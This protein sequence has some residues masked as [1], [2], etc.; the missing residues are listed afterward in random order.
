MIQGNT[1]ETCPV[2]TVTAGM[3]PQQELTEPQTGKPTP[4]VAAPVPTAHINGL[5]MQIPQVG[6]REQLLMIRSPRRR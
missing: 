6:G 2:V 1:L 5:Q 4:A 3:P